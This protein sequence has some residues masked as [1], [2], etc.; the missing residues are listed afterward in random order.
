MSVELQLNKPARMEWLDAMRGFTMILVVA[1]H[2]STDCFGQNIKHSA[3]LSFFVLFRMPLFFFV[4]GF[5][6]YSSKTVW[7]LRTLGQNL[8]KKC[9]VQLIPTVVFLAV[10]LSLMRPNFLKG[11]EVALASP[12]KSGYWFT[13]ALLLMFVIYYV[14]AY[15]ESKLPKKTIIPLL[16]LWTGATAIYAT[17]YMPSWFTYHK[18]PFFSYTS[19]IQV[20]TYF[21]FF[22]FGTMVRRYWHHAERLF[23]TKWFYTVIVVVAFICAVDY[24][25]WHTLR[26]QWANLPRTVAMYSLILIVVMFFR[27]YKEWFTKQTVVGKC[28]QYIGTRTLDIYLLHFLFLP[29]AKMI[30]GFFS[31][32]LRNFVFDATLSLVVGLLVIG[33]CLITSNILRVS[34][35]FRKYLFGRP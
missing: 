35:I 33:F 19:L 11:L 21:H 17:I 16:L 30:G 26:L 7:N 2:V 10:F 6:A 31:H 32:N 29:N 1:Y 24:L 18:A 28:L 12:T 14:F 23:D 8:L 20:M 9:K 13:W 3:A 5:L 22:L 34:P 15:L 27:H 25:K 4:S